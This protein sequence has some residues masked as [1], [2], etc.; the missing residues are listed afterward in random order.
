MIKD[1]KNRKQER[2]EEGKKCSKGCGDRR[3]EKEER[4]KENDKY[5]L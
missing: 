5:K 2:S 3:R 4:K 1:Q